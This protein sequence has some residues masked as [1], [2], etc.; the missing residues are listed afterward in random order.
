MLTKNLSRLLPRALGIT[1]NNQA[2]ASRATQHT[3]TQQQ[4]QQRHNHTWKLGK[5][6]HVAIAVRTWMW[7]LNFLNS[8][9]GFQ[10]TPSFSCLHICP[11]RTYCFQAIFLFSFNFQNNIHI[12][13]LGDGPRQIDCDVPG[14]T[15]SS[16]KWSWTSRRAWSVHGVCGTWRHKDRTSVSPRGE[17]THWGI[18][19]EKSIWRWGY[20]ILGFYIRWGLKMVKFRLDFLSILNPSSFCAVDD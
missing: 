12:T 15:R 14:R 17:F 9:Y 20:L 3:I 11:F 8:H 16:R 5:L 7:F 2:I 4:Q 13:S 18:S 1:C 19:E 6:N 10:K